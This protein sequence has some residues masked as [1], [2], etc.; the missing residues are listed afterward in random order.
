MRR[1]LIPVFIVALGLRLFFLFEAAAAPF[2]DHLIADSAYYFDW[3]RRI[4]DEGEWM[5]DRIFWVD[6]LYAYWL[7]VLYCVAGGAAPLVSLIFQALFGALTC[8]V[9]FFLGERL[10]DKKTGFLAACLAA[11]YS[12]LIFYDGLL[13]KT[14]LT[15]LLG[16][17]ALFVLL[18]AADKKLLRW[19]TAG[20]LLVGLACLARSS[21]LVFVPCVL[22]W[23]LSLDWKRIKGGVLPRM[24]VFCLGAAAAVLP[25]TIRN[26][27]VSDDF[28][29]LTANLGQNLY[30][31]NNPYNQYGTYTAPPFIQEESEHEERSWHRHAEQE[32]GKKLT[33]SEVSKFWT[34]KTVDWIAEEPGDFFGLLWKKFRLSWNWFEVP[35]NYDY[36]FYRDNMSLV[37]KAPLLNFGWLAPAALVGIILALKEWRRRLL[38]YLCFLSLCAMPVVF[39]VFARF[40]VPYTPYL[41]L[42]GAF[43]VIRILQWLKEKR[44]IKAALTL[45]G[46]AGAGLFV[47]ASIVGMDPALS[48]KPYFNM[49]TIREQEGK[50]QEAIEW[51]ERA[52][53]INPLAS[54]IYNNLG[55]A[56]WKLGREDEAERIFKEA[57]DINPRDRYAHRNLGLLYWKQGLHERA[58]ESFRSDAVVNPQHRPDLLYNEALFY[59]DQEEDEKA[60][61]SL[62]DLLRLIPQHARGLVLLA[63][64]Q[65]RTGRLR[66]A[67]ARLQQALDRD[68][69]L[70]EAH[71]LLARVYTLEDPP[72][73]EKAR[74]H[75]GKAES[76]G[77]AIPGEFRERLKD[78]EP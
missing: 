68:P 6:P 13:L 47:N 10:F 74:K 60:R 21:F 46:V 65:I 17:L 58:L 18:R 28:I 42:F 70:G 24:G 55:G 53:E 44:W 45:A 39:F 48:V 15:T 64:V 7:A 34:G 54:E 75:C 71:F 43:A 49:G 73:F 76:L 9:L 26:Y 30:L 22:L 66:M 20:G 41:C 2:F 59:F 57:I 33:P 8:I 62:Q 36:Y 14:S 50:F 67:K 31:G 1:W 16:C 61:G 37:L 11:V 56:L 77:F 69:S 38:L 27:A 52:I 5:G 23:A 32:Q 40:R 35:D 29:L 25:V 78:K 12:P 63:K 51:Y 19:W 4:V 72:D 3:A